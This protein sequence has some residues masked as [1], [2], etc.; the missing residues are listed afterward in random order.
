MAE[1][2]KPAKK[3]SAQDN[4]ELA[5]IDPIYQKYVRSVI[6][7]LGS[8]EFYNFFMEALSHADNQIQ[9]SN[10]RVEKVV[11][12]RWVEAIEDSLRGFQNIISSPRN[13]IREDELI[14]NVANAKKAGSDVVQH[15]AMHASLVEKF[16]EDTGE[17]RPSKLM[18][19]YRED[20]IGR[21]YENRVVYTVLE[22]A[23]QFVRQRY[24]ALTQVMGEEFGAKLKVNTDMLTATEEVR[25]DTFIHIKDID[26]AL[27][28]DDKNRGVFDRI[29]RLE[30]VLTINMNSHFARHMSKVARVKGQLT[31][32]NML[33]KDPNYKAIA[34]LWDF[35]REYDEVGYTIKIIEQNPVI[36][37]KFERDIFHNVLFNYLVL[38]GHLERDKD[39][40]LP[41]PLKQKQRSLKPKYI[42]EIIE[43]LTED[44]DLPEV[45][46]RK[47]LIEELTKEQ[48]MLEEAEE[49]RRLVEEAEARKREEEERIRRE[50]EAEEERRRKEIEAE[51]ER[52]RLEKEAEKERRERERREREAALTRRGNL[53]RAELDNFDAELG[54]RLD[55]REEWAHREADAIEDFEDAV[56]ILD[57]TERIK[58]EELERERQRKREEKERLERERLIAEEKARKAEEERLERERLAA[59]AREERERRERE[60]REER[61]RR[62]Q[63]EKDVATTAVFADALGLLD[64][65]VE[66]RLKD[67]REHIE[68]LEREK[69]ER[70]Q[71]RQRRI[72]ARTALKK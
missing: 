22:K 14:V 6:R 44:Y 32:T 23:H 38:K 2:K 68:K 24:E 20:S 19:K 25:M 21:L 64:G 29:A 30:R 51:K 1:T 47:V 46:I 52:K 15:L 7:S 71:E 18:Q 48:L 27:D 55:E 57:E 41:E 56:A 12:L 36:D 10:R 3:K 26:S 65:D 50:K 31:K 61:E 53:F 70:E 39:R 34:K 8:T 60:E 5:V 67:R 37:E 9:F 28:T 69:E 11:D 35:L 62:E 17:V 49:R 63:Y 66:R 4:E 13:I 40:M 59:I 43:E 72:A 45:E 58:K 16:D 33:K 42:K 54:T